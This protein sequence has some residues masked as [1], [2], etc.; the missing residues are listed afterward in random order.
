MYMQS[1]TTAENAGV[2]IIKPIAD[3]PVRESNILLIRY[4][5]NSCRK[6]HFICSLDQLERLTKLKQHSG[7]PRH[8]IDVQMSD[9]ALARLVETRGRQEQY[10]TLG[11]C[12]G[13]EPQRL[14]TTDCNI[15]TMYKGIAISILS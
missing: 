4:W 10:V 7:V 14:I 12:W 1:G 11:Y 6:N 2:E 15:S 9:Q 3:H 8:L 5:L 13:R